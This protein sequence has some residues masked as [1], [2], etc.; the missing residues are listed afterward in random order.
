MI[1]LSLISTSL[2]GHRRAPGRLLG[3]RLRNPGNIDRAIRVLADLQGMFMNC[4]GHDDTVPYLA[5][6]GEASRQVRE[7]FV[8]PEFAEQ[9]ERDQ[10]DLTLGGAVMTRPREFLDRSID[11]WQTRLVDARARLEALRPFI[12]R[13]GQIIVIDTS[14]FIEGEYFTDFNWRRLGGVQAT[15]P[16]RLIVPIIVIGELDDLKRDKRAGDRARSVLHR[17]LE[18]HG[19]APLEPVQV[20]GRQGV[21]VEVLLDH[22][23]HQRLPDNDAEIIDR[24][25]HVGELT[26]QN[27]LLV[28]GDYGMLYR[29]A[30]ASL[31]TA[32][33]PRP[34]QDGPA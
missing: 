22:P 25:V 12:E 14:A 18:L 26:G 16:V 20:S 17:L 4:R 31:G 3:M 10:R 2:G 15:G 29:A 6:C 13:P 23:R 27:V 7:Q 5:W 28:A 30:A 8:S 21:T 32:L 34:R 19:T 1:W 24:A 9:A 33:M 11:I